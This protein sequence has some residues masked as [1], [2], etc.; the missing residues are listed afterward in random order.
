MKKILFTLLPLL[1]LASCSQEGALTPELPGV[2]KEIVLSGG[3]G[4]IA[5]GVDT[6]AVID[7]GYGSVLNVSFAR[8]DKNAVGNYD[9]YG[10]A[11]NNAVLAAT[12]TGGAGNTAIAFS[13]PQYYSMKQLASAPGATSYNE[14]ALVGWYPAGGTINASSQVSLALN[15]SNDIMMTP[16]VVGSYTSPFN[17][18]PFSFQHKLAKVAVKVVALDAQ[19]PTSWGQVKAI[20]VNNQPTTCLLK[21]DDQSVAFSG[22]QALALADFTQK[23]F[24][25]TAT[26]FGYALIQPTTTNS[27][28]LNVETVNGGVRDITIGLPKTTDR[29]TAGTA[30]A[31]T[32]SFSSNT[33]SATAGIT[34]WGS[35]VDAGNVG[36]DDNENK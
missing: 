10:V 7:A 31:V 1:G 3:F 12:R 14:T 34:S 9:S 15:G 18:K 24:S 5:G 30:Y 16:Q 32:L 20:K 11:G 19:A 29:F 35:T 28:T 6:R 17:A 25:T 2:K 27:I 26:E 23:A 4:E 22:T 8:R 36:V 33:I 21:L 13:A